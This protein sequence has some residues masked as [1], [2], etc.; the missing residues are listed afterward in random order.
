MSNFFVTP[1]IATH[2][3]LLSMGFLR[4]GYKSGL[5]F[6]PWGDLP[7]PGVEPT[8]PALAGR[9]F[10]HWATRESPRARAKMKLILS[11]SP[12]QIKMQTSTHTQ[13]NCL[14]KRSEQRKKS[15]HLFRNIGV[16]VAKWNWLH[17]IKEI[18]S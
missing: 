10:Y 17:N 11:Q 9:Y 3:S 8:S 13:E 1:C 15:T 12:F 2:Q 14:R 7:D 4:Q 5:P 18:N 6:S 16:V